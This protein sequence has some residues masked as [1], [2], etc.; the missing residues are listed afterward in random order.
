MDDKKIELETLQQAIKVIKDY[1]NDDE[2][3]TLENKLI[4]EFVTIN[5]NQYRHNLKMLV[6]ETNRGNIKGGE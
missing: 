4:A 1:L 3:S 6:T 5:L 2:F